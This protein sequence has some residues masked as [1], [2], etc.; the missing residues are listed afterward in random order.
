[1]KISSLLALLSPVLASS[2]WA[3]DATWAKSDSYDL[4]LLW[5]VKANWL[6]GGVQPDDLPTNAAD[7]V[8]FPHVTTKRR[9]SVY[10]GGGWN[11]PSMRGF[12]INGVTGDSSVEILHSGPWSSQYAAQNA[13]NPLVVLNP[14]S[15]TGFW[16]A[17]D[18]QQIFAFPSSGS[19]TPHVRNLDVEGRPTLRADGDGRVEV[20]AL[21]NAGGLVK[22]GPAEV[23]IAGSMG[24]C[25]NLY[26]EEGDVVLPAF[27]DDD[28]VEDV[29][30]GAYLH[31]DASDASTFQY[32][33]G[34]DTA[35][36]NWLDVRKNGNSAWVPV[37]SSSGAGSVQRANPPFVSEERSPTGL[38]YLDFGTRFKSGEEPLH[39]PTN[40][41]MEFAKTTCGSEVFCVFRYHDAIDGMTALLGDYDLAPMQS[42]DGAIFGG[43]ANENLATGHIYLD[44][45]LVKS[46]DK[47]ADGLAGSVHVMSFGPS[48]NLVVRTIGVDQRK[49]ERCGGMLFG[50]I[51]VFTN[52]LSRADRLRLNGYLRRKWVIGGMAGKDLGLGAVM[53]RG[54]GSQLKVDEGKRARALDV[55]V[56]GGT[57][58]KNGGGVLEMDTIHPTNAVIDVR[59]GSV[60]LNRRIVPSLRLAADPIVRLDASE[61]STITTEHDAELDVDFVTSWKDC[62]TGVD[63]SAV[64]FASQSRPNHPTVKAA[65]S[66]TRLDVVDFGDSASSISAMTL[67]W[68]GQSA[69]V[70][71]GFIVMRQIAPAYSH[72]AFFG[73]KDFTMERE[74]AAD[75]NY[76][77]RILSSKYPS[78]AAMSALWTVNGKPVDP[79]V[80]MPEYFGTGAGFVVVAF[81][82]RQPLAV[83]AISLAR[84]DAARSGGIQVGEY[85]LY[86][87]ELNEEERRDTE[88]YL[89]D[90]WLGVR[91]PAAEAS[92]RP[93]FSFGE[94]VPATLDSA[95]DASVSVV[96]GGNGLI[97]KKGAGA[98]QVSAMEDV[99][100]AP[101]VSVEEGS[102]TLPV[103]SFLESALFHFDAGAESSLVYTDGVFAA[104][105][106][107]RGNGLAAEVNANGNVTTPPSP[108]VVTTTNGV[109]RKMLD[110]GYLGK[111]STSRTRLVLNR[112]FDNVR[113]AHVVLKGRS[114]NFAPFTWTEESPYA[115]NNTK[116]YDYYR[117]DSEQILHYSYSAQCLRDGRIWIDGES[118]AYTDTITPTDS[119]LVSFAPTGDTYVN[120]IQGDRDNNGGAY[121]GEQIAFDR[122]LTDQ[123][124]DYLMKKLMRK[125]FE[126]GEEPVWTNAYYS[127]VNVANGARLVFSGTSDPHVGSLSGAGEIEAE[128]LSGVGALSVDGDAVA[129]GYHLTAS[130]VVSF[131]DS[132]V[133][134]VYMHG[135]ALGPG[136][137]TV[138]EAGD[139]LNNVDLSQW[140]LEPGGLSPERTYKLRKVDNK[141]VLRVGSLGFTIFVR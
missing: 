33:E 130:G 113:E 57:L 77:R 60:A 80:Y 59:G 55:V 14:N 89:M 122:T 2:L 32:Q 22:S 39:G 135:G 36:T 9:Q 15:F 71:S 114:R 42:Y 83:D 141:I 98:V 94:S 11:V 111:A 90:K 20:D 74:N 37:W 92:W 88:A 7:N 69:R 52:E 1:M 107:V 43:S 103:H 23:R 47:P 40:C 126:A 38:R 105:M 27:A 16:G 121:I 87:R 140:T 41:C 84:G 139:G 35:V 4:D 66:P 95:V 26:V 18:T 109:Q 91:H 6:V 73:C 34:S 136:E 54:S 110:F 97:C 13:R 131:A 82:A 96:R 76:H 51:L 78:P 17:G 44:G 104:W 50:E 124:R 106:D 48:S 99:P 8:V 46:T 10:A 134:S 132:V 127:A 63:I 64:P 3:M 5:N 58:V 125:W 24:G 116:H 45:R 102:L 72:V 119:M 30:A 81:C 123:E 128:S 101:A 65:Q 112:C 86:D 115:P 108:E 28:E 75:G 100:A 79:T 49:S 67:P 29:M 25:N 120:S 19:F 137:Y 53:V 31:L 138:M 12:T 21:Y 56:E 133:V 129:S 118:R 68:Y 117:P 70:Y 62:R 85:I 61:G 93:A